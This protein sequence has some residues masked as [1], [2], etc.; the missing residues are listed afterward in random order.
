MR[1][2]QVLATGSLGSAS[3]V[4]IPFT[5]LAASVGGLLANVEALEVRLTK[6][7]GSTVRPQAATIRIRDMEEIL[8]DGT[9]SELL[10][11]MR[12]RGEGISAQLGSASATDQ[13]LLRWRPGHGSECEDMQHAAGLFHGGDL[14]ITTPTDVG[15]TTNYEVVAKLALSPT[16]LRVASRAVTRTLASGTGTLAGDFVLARARDASFSTAN[17][18]TLGVG[19]RDVLTSLTGYHAQ[20]A[21]ETSLRP[22]GDP[23]V[24]TAVA[25]TTIAGP[26]LVRVASGAYASEGLTPISKL[27]L[28]GGVAKFQS[29]WS[30][31]PLVT[32]IYPRER[33]QVRRMLEVAAARAGV[34]PP[35]SSKVKSR[36][37]NPFKAVALA[38]FMPITGKVG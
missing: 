3:S 15:Q 7:V 33:E 31:A 29:G 21:Y 18:Y 35:S 16:D 20:L 26:D 37:R 12:E 30:G 6:T 8:F 25:Q 27:P 14:L 36:S 38:R 5:S 2:A 22:A 24:L 19:S 17:T 28:S 13:C 32:A 10:A 23:V 9:G 1:A 11:Q 34:A 4:S